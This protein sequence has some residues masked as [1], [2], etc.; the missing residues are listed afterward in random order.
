MIQYLDENRK[1]LPETENIEFNKTV[2]EWTDRAKIMLNNQLRNREAIMSVLEASK[3][4]EVDP[5]ALFHVPQALAITN[6]IYVKTVKHLE[7][8][9]TMEKRAPF[10]KT[11]I[12]NHWASLRDLD[13]CITPCNIG[14]C[15]LCQNSTTTKDS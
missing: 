8:L 1:P 10:I 11:E 6:E 5:S 9:S 7:K 3:S 14:D 12:M 4:Q 2:D 13:M 15:D